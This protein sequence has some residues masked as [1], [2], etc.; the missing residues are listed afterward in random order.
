[1]EAKR[2]LEKGRRNFR[3]GVLQVERWDP[4]SGC[5]RRKGSA[6]AEWVRVVGLPLHL[7]K[8]ETLKR[9]GDACGGYLAMD[10]ITELR[11]ELS[12]ARLL[13]IKTGFPRPNTI[14]IL[15]GLRSF[16]LQIWWEVRPWVTDV[17]PVYATGASKSSK[18]EDDGEPRA[19]ERVGLDCRSCNADSQRKETEQAVAG[20]QWQT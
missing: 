2:V 17:Y 11:R 6:Q 16:E 13:V 14:N 12:W 15:E 5:T 3:E 7:W 20:G 18:E 10:K 8:T 19:K 9:I 4:Y 1:M